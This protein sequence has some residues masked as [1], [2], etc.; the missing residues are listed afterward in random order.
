MITKHGKVVVGKT[1][2][3]VSGQPSDSIVS[4]EPV[5]E[6][7]VPPVDP[8]LAKLASMVGDATFDGAALFHNLGATNN[9]A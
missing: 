8:Q 3:A 4:G 1:P 7:D 6:G 5:H 9:V 2:S